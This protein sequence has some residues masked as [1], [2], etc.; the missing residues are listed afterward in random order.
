M[1]SARTLFAA[2]VAA[3]MLS[4]CAAGQILGTADPGKKIEEAYSHL[5]ELRPL[6]AEPLIRESIEAY[7][8]GNDEA[9]LAEAYRAYGF[10]FRSQAVEKWQ[11]HYEAVGFQDKTA[12]FKNRY[13]KSAENFEESARLLAKS[14]QYDKL[15][16]VYANLGFSFEV[17]GKNDKACE[18]Y[19][20][21]REANRRFA[22]DTPG[23]SVTL[24]QGFTG[25]YEE[26]INGFLER[27]GCK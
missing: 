23:V 27:L 4:G 11:Q 17:A 20:A 9:G 19:K 3:T 22:K 21:S 13:E 14:G 12:T 1:R 6:A 15:T 2:I 16:N 10:F 7:R 25:T 8:R 18:A 26:Y 24:P 5:D